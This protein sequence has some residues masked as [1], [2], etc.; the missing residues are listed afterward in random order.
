MS[1]RKHST[2]MM[3]PLVVAL[4]SFN[5]CCSHASCEVEIPVIG[6]SVV[7][8]LQTNCD[9]EKC[10]TN[11]VECTFDK[12][13]GH[14]NISGSGILDQFF[15]SKL[16]GSKD[17]VR[18]VTVNGVS[19]IDEWCFAE[20]KSLESVSISNS[21]KKIGFCAFF[22]CEMLRDIDI[23]SSVAEFDR[24]VFVN[25]ISLKNVT[26][27]NSIKTINEGL[28]EGCTSLE[29]VVIPDSIGTIESFAFLACKSLRKI[30]IP[31]SVTK[32][33]EAAFR[34]CALSEDEKSELIKKFGS[35]IF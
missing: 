34:V 11:D 6:P 9:V 16:G 33:G 13:S 22:G 8:G 25:C 30:S 27:P 10:R 31:K 20:C 35:S 14:L 3:A 15:W 17:S 12:R 26:I 2:K 21:V 29:V 1:T 19:V 5:V 23:P 7:D 4:S 32:V 28:F 18:S 24:G